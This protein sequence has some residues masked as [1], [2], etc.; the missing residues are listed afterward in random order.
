MRIILFGPPG[1][2]KGTQAKILSA[3]LRVAHISTGDLLR[4]AVTTGTEIGR[5]AKTI[6]DAG[7][8]VSDDIMIA[9]IRDVLQSSKCANGFIVDGFPRTVPQAEALSKLMVELKLTFDAVIIMDIDHEEIVKRLSSRLSCKE[10]GTIFNLLIDT[11]ES[12]SDCPKCGGELYMR[13]DDKPETIRERLAVYVKSTSPVK[14]YYQRAG[15]LKNVVA[16]GTI[17]D[18]NDSILSILKM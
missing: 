4:E 9:I 2:G 6:M 12:T 11:I 15:V 5:K 7:Q 17:D 3:R 16:V 18:V 1:V 13:D 10:C 8:L 14:E